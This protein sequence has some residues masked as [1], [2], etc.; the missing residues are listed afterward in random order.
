LCPEDKGGCGH[1]KHHSRFRSKSGVGPNST[2]FATLCKDCEL[3][4]KHKRKN[5]DRALW[6]V[7]E[8]TRYYARKYGLSFDFMFKE[9]NFQSLVPG[10]R[11][12]MTPEAS[13]TNCGHAFDSEPDIQFDHNSPPRH[14]NDY[15]RIHARNITL[16]CASCNGGKSD[17]PYDDWLDQE[18]MRRLSNK[19]N[20]Y[21]AKLEMPDWSQANMFSNLPF[22]KKA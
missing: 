12:M 5:E 6:I 2:K 18:E 13:C 17:T 8:R 11:A 3:E 19:A 15:A 10:M 21:L 4:E 14:D 1:W 20:P 7:T 16:R 22:Q 9:M